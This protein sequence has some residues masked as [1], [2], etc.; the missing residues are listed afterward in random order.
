M[1]DLVDLS[2]RVECILDLILLFDREAKIGIQVGTL[3]FIAYRGMGKVII[4]N[5]LYHTMQY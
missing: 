2:A 5:I 4:L 1:L 3:K